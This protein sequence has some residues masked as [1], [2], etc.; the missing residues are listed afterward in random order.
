ML[1]TIK[2]GAK[3]DLVKVAQ[4]LAEYGEVSG[5]FDV[6]FKAHIMAWQ[7]ERGLDAD[8]IIGPKTWAAIA[9][10]A[11]TVSQTILRKG[12]YA[13]AA[14]LLVGATPDGIFGKKSAAAVVA[15]QA[16]A[17]LTA[18]GVVDTGTWTAL[19]CDGADAAATGTGKVL[20]TCAH[21]LQWDKRWKAVMYSNHGDKKQT[22]GS[23]GCGPTSLAM[24]MASWIDKTITPVELCALAVQGGYRTY[25]SGTAWGFFGDVA[26]R[27]PQFSKFIKTGNLSTVLAAIRAGALVV[28][29]MNG[30][31]NHFWTKGGHY[32]TVTGCDEGYIYA[33]DPNKS[34]HPRKQA[35][36][37]FKSCMKQAFIFYK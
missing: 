26:G 12:K 21:Y 37:K 31:D 2:K 9:Q 23:S 25:D 35:Q 6:Q 28:C 15:F 22:I 13:Q 14:Q 17:G 18:N 5:A 33:N 27:Y 32:I 1:K 3:G 7:R 4:I 8:G 29:S 19:I 10:G 20:N 11:P 24:I 36:T 16:A 30:G 34:A